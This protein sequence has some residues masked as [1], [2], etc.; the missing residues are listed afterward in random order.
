M[1][2]SCLLAQHKHTFSLDTAASFFLLLFCIHATMRCFAF[3]LRTSFICVLHNSR[4]S[5]PGLV[6]LKVRCHISAAVFSCCALK[7]FLPRAFS[8]S[9]PLFVLQYAFIVM[10]NVSA[11]LFMIGGEKETECSD[12]YCNKNRKCFLKRKKRNY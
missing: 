2:S 4:S 11:V 9:L 8:S 3:P 12:C 7:D 1:R 10:S 6:M 5:L